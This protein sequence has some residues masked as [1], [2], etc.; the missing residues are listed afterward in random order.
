MKNCTTPNESSPLPFSRISEFT[1]LI[2]PT[3]TSSP[4]LSFSIHVSSLPFSSSFLVPSPPGL[5]LLL[6]LPPH[7]LF[8]PYV[9]LPPLPLSSPS[10]SPLL[11]SPHPRRDRP[12]PKNERDNYT[13]RRRP[14]ETQQQTDPDTNAEADRDPDSERNC[15]SRWLERPVPAPR[16]PQRH[17]V[18]LRR[19]PLHRGVRHGHCLRGPRLLPFGRVLPKRRGNAGSD[20]ELPFC[21]NIVCEVR[22]VEAL[23]TFSL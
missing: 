13:D 17:V 9:S 5:S 6:H 20:S 23:L 10:P 3:L 7:F 19:N 18:P 16:Q 2:A 1:D 21:L 12:R 22:W 8:S 15:T 11:S 14:T 4:A